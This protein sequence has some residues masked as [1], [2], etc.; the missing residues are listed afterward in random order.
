MNGSDDIVSWIVAIISIAF[1]AYVGL[2]ILSSISEMYHQPYKQQLEQ[3]DKEIASL[4]KQIAQLQGEIEK[5]EQ[6]Y[7]QLK[8]ETI[9]REDIEMLKHYI[10]FT[11]NKVNLLSQKLEIVNKNFITAYNTYY[12]IFSVSLVLNIAFVGYIAIDFISAT[13]FEA[14]ITMRIVNKIKGRKS[15]RNNKH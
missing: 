6:K 2:I 5:W 7:S 10:N 8:N 15:L 11:Q 9:S 3:K 4:K 12:T 14:S 1:I 13:L